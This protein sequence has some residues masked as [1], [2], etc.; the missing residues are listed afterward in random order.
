[1]GPPVNA[2]GPAIS[3]LSSGRRMSN[4][5]PA[6]PGVADRRHAVAEVHQKHVS[7][8]ER[9]ELTVWRHVVHVYVKTSLPGSCLRA[10]AA[11]RQYLG[12]QPLACIVTAPAFRPDGTMITE[13]GYDAITR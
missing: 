13:P 9:R 2:R 8:A 10:I 6:I 3:P 12:L 7:A 4:I 1:M 5:P 11:R